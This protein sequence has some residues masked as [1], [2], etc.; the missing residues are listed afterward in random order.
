MTP[1]EWSLVG[2]ARVNGLPAIDP[3]P[4]PIRVLPLELVRAWWTHGTR[5]EGGRATHLVPA[6][7]T[8]AD[9]ITARI[10]LCGLKLADRMNLVQLGDR[11]PANTPE[12]LTD[13]ANCARS[14]TVR[15]WRAERFR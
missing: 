4:E 7:G 12:P 15:Q 14:N 13:C 3:P 2:E 8:E 9:G 1:P 10:T 11:L 6:W 5:P